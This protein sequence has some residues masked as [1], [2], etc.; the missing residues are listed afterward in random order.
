MKG[1]PVPQPVRDLIVSRV[2]NGEKVDDLAREFSL[3]PN[4]IRK[5]L[6][7]HNYNS[8]SG[9]TTTSKSQSSDILLISKLRR[10]KQELL[11]II[12]ELTVLTK[13]SKK[14]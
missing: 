2:T 6:K 3:Y 11:E 10:E 7:D 5:W 13:R 4:T 9:N 8:T 1:T 14:N 12:G